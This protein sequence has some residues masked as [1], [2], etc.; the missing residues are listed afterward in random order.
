MS[1]V[2]FK[3]L[4]ARLGGARTQHG[5]LCWREQRGKAQVLLIT[6]RRTGRWVIP[7]GWPHGN[8]RPDET[9]LREAAEEAGVEGLL[10]PDCLGLYSY[11][12][13]PDL[14]GALPCMVTVYP[15]E[16]LRLAE[17]WP[18]SGTRRRKWF[19]P[20]KAAAEVGEKE[21]A[22]LLRGFEPGR[23]QR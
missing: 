6:S 19:S 22:R 8:E 11:V 10:H 17:D 21:L 5:A 18:E 1:N 9:A 7:K 3:M 13:H 4:T 15:V 14:T 12:K 20:R 16:V 23:L 2:S